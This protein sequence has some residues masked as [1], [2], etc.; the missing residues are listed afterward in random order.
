MGNT[1]STASRKES[2]MSLAQLAV[3]EMPDRNIELNSTEN[4]NNQLNNNDNIAGNDGV[5]SSAGSS[6][7]GSYTTGTSSQMSS[8]SS[9]SGDSFANDSNGDDSIELGSTSDAG[10]TTNLETVNSSA[11]SDFA[12]E[13]D[14]VRSLNETRMFLLILQSALTIGFLLMLFQK[15][16]NL[17]GYSW[18]IILSPLMFCNVIR[19]GSKL[20]EAYRLVRVVRRYKSHDDIPQMKFC[21][22]T[23]PSDTVHDAIS[24]FLEFIDNLGEGI[25]TFAIGLYLQKKISA[26]LLVVLVPFWCEMLL[27]TMVR[28]FGCRSR[29]TG[30]G[31]VLVG[32]M[33]GFGYV[34]LKGIPAGK[35]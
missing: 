31:S 2:F 33:K 30:L 29:N 15:L 22:I 10:S 34:S 9:A 18:M 23:V 20:F 17:H 25:T 4:N 28:C 13:M 14:Q 24:I 21:C 19:M 12:E 35:F 26:P 3:F 5:S 32:V 16:D 1:R 11:Q 27:G 6:T 8:Q 7:E